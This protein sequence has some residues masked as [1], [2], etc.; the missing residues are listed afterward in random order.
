MTRRAR[1]A[2]RGEWRAPFPAAADF[3]A[4]AHRPS[5][6]PSARQS[7]GSGAG[8]FLAMFEQLTDWDNLLNA[9]RKAARGK[10]GRPAV[11]AFEYRLEENLFELQAE[12]L[13]DRYR[14]G[15]YQ[16]FYI[17]EPKR[18]LVA[19]APFRDRVVHH[20]LCNCIEPLFEP[21]FV[22]DSYANRIGKGSHR[23]MHRAQALARRYRYVLQLDVQ[24]FFP[25][26][27]H[28]IL[29]RRLA[30]R[31]HD[32]RVLALIDAILAGGLDATASTGD[33]PFPGDDLLSPLRP[34]GLPVGNLTSQF[35]GNLYLDGLDH[36]VRRTLRCEG[37]V[38]YVDDL[39]LFGDDRA[40]LWR[41]RGEASAFL[42]RLRLRF[43][44]GAQV[45]PVTEGI[46][47]LGFVVYPHRLPLKARR[48]VAFQRRLRAR[49]AEVAA[50]WLPPDAVRQSLTG[51]LGHARQG[52]T[53]SLRQAM[54]ALAAGWPP[55]A[56]P[57]TPR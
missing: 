26:I 43:H 12:L 4:R 21:G 35:W 22:A 49:K 55:S 24:Q 33:R 7:A 39:L 47:F 9:F 56:A 16:R 23:A 19:A 53:R 8:T 15:P 34:R 51:W 30:R 42:E 14:P 36:F 50:G 44:P 2:G 29:R 25:S 31:V 46:P 54:G 18:R 1:L 37:Y 45:R 3:P 13:E 48:V 27:D 28:A 10:R 11:A 20:A 52:D 17:H 41:W 57:D 40:A 5:P 6:A 32:P 38:R